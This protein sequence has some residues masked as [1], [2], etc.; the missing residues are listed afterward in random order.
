MPLADIS[1][2]AVI[3]G[4]H[5]TRHLRHIRRKSEGKPRPSSLVE[6][7]VGQRRLCPPRFQYPIAA[8]AL[9]NCL[10]FNEPAGVLNRRNL[11]F[12][13]KKIDRRGW[14]FPSAETRPN[15][16]RRRERIGV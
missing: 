3:H 7:E 16:H 15:R 14:T 8:Y 10:A 11:V 1:I 2:E 12:Q 6:Q 4:G 13:E 5:V 9:A